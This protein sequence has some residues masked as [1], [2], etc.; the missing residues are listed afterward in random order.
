M[1]NLDPMSRTPVYEQ[2]IGQVEKFIALGIL[3]PGDPLPSVRN[4]SVELSV[5]PNT[6]QKTFN[7]LY[8]RGLTVS[9]PGRGSFISNEAPEIIRNKSRAK[10]S[11]FKMLVKEL[12]TAGLTED[13]LQKS[14]HEA[15]CETVEA[16][17][18]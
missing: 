3:N 12:F 4:L 1:F 9:V 2:I 14:L 16:K 17:Q 18:E 7:E 13:E 15:V 6:I 10:L 8:S 5:N 11:D